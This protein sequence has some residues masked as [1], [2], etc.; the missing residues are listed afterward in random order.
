MERVQAVHVLQTTHSYTKY[1]HKKKKKK[2]LLVKKE[3]QQKKA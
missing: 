1:I 2:K 3:G